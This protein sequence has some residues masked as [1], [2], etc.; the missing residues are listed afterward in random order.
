MSQAIT[1]S[2]QSCKVLQQREGKYLT[3]TLGHERYGLEIMKVRAIIG[4]K[5][6]TSVF[7]TRSH[8]KG[9]INLREQEIPVVDLRAEFGMQ[10][11]DVTE[12]S[13]IIVVEIIQSQHNF[14][15]GII[16]DQV[17]EIVD[18]AGENIRESTQ[19]GTS[20]N[21]DYILGIGKNGAVVNILL[22]IDK[23][24]SGI[25]FCV[26]PSGQTTKIPHPIDE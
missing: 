7:R 18:I 13:C 11:A 15:V 10:T 22:D 9:M 1:Q 8:V 14:S 2:E 24:L 20:V 26:S 12:R 23:V 19:S 21:T 25:D 6:M 16:V 5:D 4:C 3:F 17:Q